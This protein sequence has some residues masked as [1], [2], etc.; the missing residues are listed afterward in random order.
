MAV[1][2]KLSWRGLVGTRRKPRASQHDKELFGDHGE[3]G[4]AGA[5]DGG[6]RADGDAGR[7]WPEQSWR[8]TVAVVG[9][10]PL[11]STTRSTVMRCCGELY[12]LVMSYFLQ[13]WT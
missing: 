12:P 13:P 3:H 9:M 7:P 4:V 5:S 8:P 10:A 6:E 1:F 2:A 11:C